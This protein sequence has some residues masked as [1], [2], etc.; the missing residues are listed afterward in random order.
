ME[1]P[2]TEAKKAVPKP[3]T[4]IACRICGSLKLEVTHTRR[5]AGA[6]L[7]R[8]RCLACGF[9]FTTRERELY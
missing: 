9:R 5:V 3:S 4:G 7:R 8:R 1:E 6:I 2:G